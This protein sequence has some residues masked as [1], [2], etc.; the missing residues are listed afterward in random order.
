MYENYVSMPIRSE[1]MLKTPFSTAKPHDSYTIN[2]FLGWGGIKKAVFPSK[3]GEVVCKIS[4]VCFD[5]VRLGEMD[6]RTTH[7]H[8]N[9]YTTENRKSPL[10][11]LSREAVSIGG[12]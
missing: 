8:I 3:L 10:N 6:T 4:D 12:D 1:V 2:K 11:F 5:W 7:I 9:K